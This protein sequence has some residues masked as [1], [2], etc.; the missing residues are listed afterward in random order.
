M[1]SRLTIADFTA[2][3]QP[4]EEGRI[5]TRL[6]IRS[7]SQTIRAHQHNYYQIVIPLHGAIQIE[8]SNT[9]SDLLL[10]ERIGPD[11]GVI[12]GKQLIHRF[13]ADEKA[14]FL[15][16]DLDQLPDVVSQWPQALFQLSTS[17]KAYCQFI[18]LQ[19]NSALNP[20]LEQDIGQLF[21]QLLVQQQ[22][23]GR[24]D[25]RIV[26]V[27]EFLQQDLS[28]TPELDT[29]A[30][31]ACLSLSQYKNLFRQ[32]VG[33]STGQYLL[34]LRMEKAKALLAHTDIPIAIIALQVGYQNAS[35]FSRRFADFYGQSPK[36]F[37]H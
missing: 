18:E 8:L 35:A 7:Y 29:L 15:V 30:Q 24:Q 12:I 10:T 14:R 16:A 2:S 17:L 6:S 1:P 28:V 4:N 20:E 36:G 26:R 21:V 25:E 37:R 23:S 9:N 11:K 32:I 3:D 13:A 33:C 5:R 34:Q 19:L 22:S 31:L 27:M